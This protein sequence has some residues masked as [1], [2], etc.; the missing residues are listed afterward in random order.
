VLATG[1]PCAA[2]AEMKRQVESVLAMHRE[3]MEGQS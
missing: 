1:D 3:G 2:A